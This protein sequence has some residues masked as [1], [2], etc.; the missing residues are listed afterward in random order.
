MNKMGMVRRIDELGRVVIPK[1]IRSLLKLNVGEQMEIFLQDE[2]LIVQ[3]FSRLQ[4]GFEEVELLG[5]TLAKVGGCEVAITDNNKVIWSTESPCINQLLTK[6]WTKAINKRKPSQAKELEMNWADRSNDRQSDQ[7]KIVVKPE[8]IA[9]DIFQLEKS[10]TPFEYDDNLVKAI[11]NVH[12]FPI[13]SRGDLYG[14]VTIWGMV[15][16]D[17][18]AQGKYV[19]EFLGSCIDG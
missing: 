13:L 7:S 11:Q 8:E 12:I 3:R 14:S 15:D 1:E 2:K 9:N 6:E 10:K 16:E 4:S 5:K 19:R 18:I 17:A